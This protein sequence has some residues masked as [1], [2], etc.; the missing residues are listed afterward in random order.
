[1]AFLHYN[2]EKDYL[3]TCK[4]AKGFENIQSVYIRVLTWA[5]C[6]RS[7]SKKKFVCTKI[8][9]K[10]W[11]YWIYQILNMSVKKPSADHYELRITILFM[12]KFLWCPENQGVHDLS[13]Y[14]LQI[15]L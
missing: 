12:C 5:S 14:S 2:Y 1:M 10:E 4:G 13:F 11:I 7:I 9:S 3:F 8:R 15:V 6:R